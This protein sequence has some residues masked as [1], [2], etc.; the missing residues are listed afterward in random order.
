MSQVAQYAL[1]AGYVLVGLWAYER[2]GVRLGGVLALPL[3]AVYAL[4]VPWA[5]EIFAFAAV[6]AFVGG[7]VLHRRTL[8]YGR[9]LF[10]VHIVASVAASFVFTQA[11]DVPLNGFLLPVLPGVFA[12]NLH[13]EGRPV[14]GAVVFVGAL[15]GLMLAGLA[16]ESLLQVDPAAALPAAMPP[17]AGGGTLTNPSGGGV[18][19]PCI[20]WLQTNLGTAG[21]DAGT[22]ALGGG[23]VL[24]DMTCGDAE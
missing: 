2:W 19:M 15:I 17:P 22:L 8:M 21:A 23:N 3:V 6:V 18:L 1:L 24:V 5:L 14:Q 10:A 13:R 16:I 20:E 7:E 9:R 11:V 4:I 12:F